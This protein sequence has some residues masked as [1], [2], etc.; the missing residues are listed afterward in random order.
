MKEMGRWEARASPK[1]PLSP[2]VMQKTELE[3]QSEWESWC[4]ELQLVLGVWTSP[5][6]G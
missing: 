5:S 4:S 2:K 3:D 6:V 1:G